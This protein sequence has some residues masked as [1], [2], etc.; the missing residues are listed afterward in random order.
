[1]EIVG[2]LLRFLQNR[3]LSPNTVA[4]YARDLTLLFRF[5]AGGSVREWYRNL[6]TSIYTTQV[7]LHSLSVVAEQASY[8]RARFRRW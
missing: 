7:V 3:S 1:M 6:R 5:L 4:A 8:I 2:R